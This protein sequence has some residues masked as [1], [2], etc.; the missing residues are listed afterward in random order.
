MIIQSYFLII[1]VDKD[2]R[3]RIKATDERRKFPVLMIGC[4]SDRR[5][6]KKSTQYLNLN[7][8]LW[9]WMEVKEKNRS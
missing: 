3:E 9:L 7:V 8:K 4:R 5:P 6:M 2:Y 1:I